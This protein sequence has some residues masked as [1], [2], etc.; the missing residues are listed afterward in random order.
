MGFNDAGSGTTVALVILQG[1][2]SIGKWALRMNARKIPPDGGG[3]APFS[4]H[5]ILPSSE[6]C[7]LA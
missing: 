4:A 1:Y 5:A 6:F 7:P 3:V 2:I